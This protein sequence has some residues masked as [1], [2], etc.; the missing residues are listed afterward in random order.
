MENKA[1]TCQMVFRS[2]RVRKMRARVCGKGRSPS[3]GAVA[4]RALRVQ[5]RTAREAGNVQPTVNHDNLVRHA[6]N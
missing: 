6:R 2:K 5:V 3:E 4:Q 1:G